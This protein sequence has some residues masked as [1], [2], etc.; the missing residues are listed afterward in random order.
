MNQENS[1]IIVGVDCRDL[2]AIEQ[3][4]DSDLVYAGDQL[5]PNGLLNSKKKKSSRL[6]EK[7]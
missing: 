7:E 2:E 1:I 4:K 3:I 6:A 5:L